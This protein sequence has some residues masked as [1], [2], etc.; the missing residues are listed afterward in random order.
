MSNTAWSASGSVV[1]I[2]KPTKNS[3]IA[4]ARISVTREGR[5]TASPPCD[6]NATATLKSVDC[7]M[8]GH[9]TRA[10]CRETLSMTCTRMALPRPLCPQE[11]LLDVQAGATEAADAPPI[12]GQA[13]PVD[14]AREVGRFAPGQRPHPSRYIA[15]FRL[16]GGL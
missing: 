11:R 15:G 9:S 13:V 16:G 2:S 6:M 5:M 10:I 8:R 3:T 4:P 1:R 14:D 12:G 7:S